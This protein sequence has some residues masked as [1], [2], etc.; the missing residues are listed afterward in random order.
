MGF[1]EDIVALLSPILPTETAVFSDPPPAQFAVV[2]PTFDFLPIYGDDMPLA[3]VREAQV[4][5]VSSGSY[6]A[7]RRE[8]AAALL[9]AGFAI[10]EM[11]YLGRE[12]NTGKM[13][14]A[15][16]VRREEGTDEIWQ[17]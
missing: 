12:E 13:S 3:A 6:A 9:G 11:Q 14:F 10:H 15:F 17:S 1:I 8:I 4:T 2:E 16:V 7:K 5:L